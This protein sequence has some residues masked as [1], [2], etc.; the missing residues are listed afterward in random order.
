MSYD[1]NI[2]SEV[3]QSRENWSTSKLTSDGLGSYVVE[4][5]R[6]H[7]VALLVS[8]STSIS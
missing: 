7:V 4:Y 6:I 5:L 8:I 2:H 1:L 3:T